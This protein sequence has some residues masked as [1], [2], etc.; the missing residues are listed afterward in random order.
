MKSM[1]A[2]VRP[3][4][5]PKIWGE[6]YLITTGC[7]SMVVDS[8]VSDSSGIIFRNEGQIYQNLNF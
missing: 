7:K 3:W 8:W 1:V 2:D 4:R 6:A 5:V